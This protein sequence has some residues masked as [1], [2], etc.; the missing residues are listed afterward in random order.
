M[1]HF[2][3]K[4][5]HLDTDIHT[6]RILYEYG[7]RDWG[8]ASVSQIMPKIARKPPEVNGETWK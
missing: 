4:R 8:D 7:G 2:L 1:T 5:G 6:G 3:I